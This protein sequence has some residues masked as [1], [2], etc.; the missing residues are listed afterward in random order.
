MRKDW[1]CSHQQGYQAEFRDQKPKVFKRGQA[2]LTHFPTFLTHEKTMSRFENIWPQVCLGTV[3]HTGSGVLVHCS[4][5]GYCSIH[6]LTSGVLVHCSAHCLT[7]GT[8]AYYSAHLQHYRY[9]LVI[10]NTH[11]N[12]LQELTQHFT[13]MLPWQTGLQSS[14][15]EHFT[16]AL[17]YLQINEP[18]Q[19]QKSTRKKTKQTE[20]NNGLNINKCARPKS[21]AMHQQE[22]D[23][24]TGTG[25]NTSSQ[26]GSAV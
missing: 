24:N 12:E 22:V 14:G 1:P 5:P 4:A 8:P 11:Y 15:H 2:T 7:S 9:C 3:V 13:S 20:L 16:V 25:L 17:T 21:F 18:K 10:N 6:C 26:P 23:R 19:T